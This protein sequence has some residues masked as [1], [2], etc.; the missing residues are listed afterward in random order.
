MSRKAVNQEVDSIVTNSKNKIKERAEQHAALLDSVKES[1]SQLSLGIDSIEI[2]D[3]IIRIQDKRQLISSPKEDEMYYI[4]FLNKK[5]EIYVI[6]VHND[7]CGYSGKEEALCSDQKL[8]DMV[9]EQRIKQL[10]PNSKIYSPQEGKPWDE[11]FNN[12]SFKLFLTNE[13]EFINIWENIH[14]WVK[15]DWHDNTLKN[16]KHS[17]K[18]KNVFS[19]EINYDFSPNMILLHQQAQKAYENEKEIEAVGQWDSLA[20]QE[21]KKIINSLLCIED[22]PQFGADVL[23]II[24]KIKP[25]LAQSMDGKKN[26]QDAIKERQKADKKL[27]RS[28]QT[29]LIDWNDW[30]KNSPI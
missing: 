14:S 10:A 5:G 11:I 18:A 29:K 24:D 27:Y 20:Q 1:F 22:H 25:M 7:F 28:F 23:K 17:H 3:E 26:L 13:Q 16:H 4:D 15:F 6:S 19:I 9:D 21:F 2:G 30:S 8:S 12:S